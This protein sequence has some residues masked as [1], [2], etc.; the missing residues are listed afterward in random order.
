M[1]PIT[2]DLTPAEVWEEILQRTRTNE[3]TFSP[4]E[5]EIIRRYFPIED[6]KPKRHHT[7]VYRVINTQTGRILFYDTLDDVADIFSVSQATIINRIN[8]KELHNDTYLIERTK[9]H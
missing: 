7:Y 1:T 3:G 5:I 2:D 9:R 8:Y 6:P 4:E